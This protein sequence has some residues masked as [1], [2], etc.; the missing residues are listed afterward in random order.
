MSIIRRS[1]RKHNLM[2]LDRSFLNDPELSW[3]AK[4]YWA[5]L[6]AIEEEGVEVGNPTAEEKKLIQEL[7]DQGYIAGEE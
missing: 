3:A 1:P 4:G 5:Y 6:H 2:V 7:I